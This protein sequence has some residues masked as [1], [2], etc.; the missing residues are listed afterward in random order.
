[1]MNSTAFSI[2]IPATNPTAATVTTRMPRQ[3]AVRAENRA[4][5]GPPNTEGAIYDAN[6]AAAT[7]ALSEWRLSAETDGPN[8]W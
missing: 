8:A 2:P 4:A 7:T 5:I 6:T 3:C 1:M